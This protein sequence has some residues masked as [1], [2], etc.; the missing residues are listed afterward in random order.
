MKVEYA[1]S[2]LGIDVD[3]I[4]KISEFKN[5]KRNEQELNCL[6][7][8]INSYIGLYDAYFEISEGQYDEIVKRLPKS[9]DLIFC[10][11]ESK[12]RMYNPPRWCEIIAIDNNRIFPIVYC[13][14]DMGN[15]VMD[16][17]PK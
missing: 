12:S 4:I 14:D 2:Q 9:G 11:K 13:N 7:F 5:A 3:M 8:A 16:S 6:F 15:L 1:F 17:D 10:I